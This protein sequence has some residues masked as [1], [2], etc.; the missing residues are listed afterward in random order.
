MTRKRGECLKN[1]EKDIIYFLNMCTTEDA[2]LFI[3]EPKEKKLEDFGRFLCLGLA[4]NMRGVILNT[5]AQYESIGNIDNLLTYTK[6]ITYKQAET[7]VEDFLEKID[8]AVLKKC[9]QSIWEEKKDY[10]AN[11]KFELSGML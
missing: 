8:N 4:F 11:H 5:F 10:F 7:W 1:L 2:N 9:A 3:S 6:T